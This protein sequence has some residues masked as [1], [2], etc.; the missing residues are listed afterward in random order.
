MEEPLVSSGLPG[1]TRVEEVVQ[2][3]RADELDRGDGEPTASVLLTLT[4]V[5]E[6]VQAFRGDSGV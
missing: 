6:V 1:L 2:A 4:R 5:E 3:I